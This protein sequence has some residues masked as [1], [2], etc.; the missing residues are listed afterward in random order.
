MGRVIAGGTYLAEREFDRKGGSGRPDVCKTDSGSGWRLEDNAQAHACIA[1]EYPMMNRNSDRTSGS[2]GPWAAVA[3]TLLLC[4]STIGQTVSFTGVGQL[5]GG[6]GSRCYEVSADGTMI[7]GDAVNSSG[8]TVAVIYDLSNLSPSLVNIGFLAPGVAN[9]YSNGRGIGV[10]SQGTVHVSGTSRNASGRNQAFL[11]SGDRAGNGTFTGIPFL[12][13]SLQDATGERLHISPGDAVSV[14]GRD[15]FSSPDYKGFYWEMG[16]PDNEVL[17]GPYADK[18]SYAIDIGYRATE[19]KFYM[20]GWHDGGW[21]D[22]ASYGPNSGLWSFDGANYS[23]TDQ[24]GL[25]KVCGGEPW[26][27]SAGPDGVANTATNADNVQVVPVGTTGLTEPDA[28]VI[29]AGLDNR[30]KEQLNPTPDDINW[31]IGASYDTDSQSFYRGI[32]SNTRY[33][34]GRSTYHNE[35]CEPYC[36]H[37]GYPFQAHLR[38]QHNRD[39]YGSDQCG[40]IAFMWPLGFLPD[41]D[42]DPDEVDDN[43]SEAFGVSN[44]TGYSKTSPRTGLVVVGYSRQIGWN[45]RAGNNLTCDTLATGDDVQLVPFGNAVAS[46]ST[47]VVG[48]GPNG[49]IDTAPG[50]DDAVTHAGGWINE[51]RAF[52]CFIKDQTDPQWGGNTDLWFLRHQDAADGDPGA[53][54][55]S[56]F[57]DMKDLKV[58][59]T[60]NGIDMTGWELREARGVSDEGT[61]IVGWGLHDGTEEGFVVNVVP[62][63]PPGACCM[64]TGWGSGTCTLTDTA[65]E[66]VGGTWLGSG[67][68]CGQCEFCPDPFADTDR[69]LDVDQNDLAVF[70]NCFTG[71]GGGVPDGCECLDRDNAGAGDGDIDEDDYSAFES[72]ASG[73]DVPAN[74]LCDG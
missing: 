28:I 50:G 65:E 35:P 38:D 47:W 51:S 31:P 14:V 70:Q 37:D 45:I 60:D 11:W 19:L 42:S 13:G 61:V 12:S 54:A 20:A 62:A 29:S 5:S 55:A 36:S 32:S 74:P 41:D 24:Y 57:K 16:E 7:V 73:P 53:S 21:W 49:V 25:E 22:P 4:S 6:T 39:D 18:R 44:G 9:K 46:S 40:G 71:I 48:H 66:C 69:D 43:C 3:L 15:K 59:L 64:L 26:Q 52:V 10:D 56:Q 67:S 1:V 30:L 58:W 68:T 72:C 33:M 63:P 17:N 27:I 23:Y 34:V 2:V 8:E